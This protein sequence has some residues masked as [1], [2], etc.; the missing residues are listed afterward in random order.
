MVEE[1]L[2]K[3]KEEFQPKAALDNVAKISA[4]HRIQ[5][6]PG[7]RE[8]AR[9]IHDSLCRQGIQVEVLSFPA[10]EGVRWWSQQSFKEWACDDAELVLL[11]D[12]KKERLCSFAETKTSIIQRSAPT[13][14]EGIETSIVLVED[15]ANPASYEG[16]D[17]ACR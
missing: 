3:I 8:A 15:G 11:E 6:S 9:Y 1:R 7:Y 12:G 10:T 17:V 16:L 5:C 4:F 13:P 14:A 2:S